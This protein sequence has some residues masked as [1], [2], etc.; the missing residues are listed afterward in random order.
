MNV[1]AVDA[2]LDLKITLKDA[3]G[4]LS[5][6]SNGSKSELCTDWVGITCD[7]MNHVSA[8]E[9]DALNLEGNINEDIKNLTYLRKL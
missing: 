5:S 1:L 4:G 9:L 3:S 7:S 8:V 2:L 6:W